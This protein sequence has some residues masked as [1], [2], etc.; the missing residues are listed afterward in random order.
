METT[1]A[2]VDVAVL[3][4]AVQEMSTVLVWPCVMGGSLVSV[5]STDPSDE[6][7]AGGRTVA[8]GRKGKLLCRQFVAVKERPARSHLMRGVH[9]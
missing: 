6:A 5:Q 2:S 8:G 9:W 4:G 1:T 3:A 7:E